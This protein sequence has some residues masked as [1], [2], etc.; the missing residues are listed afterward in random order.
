MYFL[1][2]SILSTMQHEVH[3]YIGS[4][5]CIYIYSIRIHFQ[6]PQFR[7]SM[8]PCYL[9]ML[10]TNPIHHQIYILFLYLVYNYTCKTCMTEQSTKFKKID[11]YSGMKSSSKKEDFNDR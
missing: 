3:M 4:V 9:P 7:N 10:T 8:F 1:S 5:L 2:N 11:S 6:T